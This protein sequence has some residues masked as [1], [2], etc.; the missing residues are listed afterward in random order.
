MEGSVEALDDL[1][2]DLDLMLVNGWRAT[3]RDTKVYTFQ[4]A[5]CLSRLDCIYITTTTFRTAQNWHICKADGV[6]SDHSMVYVDL[7]HP[8]A[9]EMGKGHP[10]CSAFLLKDKR[11]VKQVKDSGIK[12]E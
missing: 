1:K 11:L 10:V 2:A 6:M 9:L 7:V 8:K 5:G 12:G 4:W 3:Y